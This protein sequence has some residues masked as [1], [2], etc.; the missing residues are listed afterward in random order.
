MKGDQTGFAY[1]ETVTPEAMLKAAR[2]AANIASSTAASGSVNIT[3]YMPPNYYPI[4]NSWENTSISSKIPFLLRM[5]EKIFAGDK[6][7]T[8]VN[9]FLIDSSSYILFYNSEGK[10][11]W[12]YRPMAVLVGVCIMEDKGRIEN[13]ICYT[14]LQNRL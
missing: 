1:S 10:L 3:E 2:T 7:V 11:A 14:R 12:D 9:A 13:F 6:R 8:K 5:N 4:V